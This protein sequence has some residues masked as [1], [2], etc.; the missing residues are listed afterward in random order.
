MIVTDPAMRKKMERALENSSYTLD[1]IEDA[2]LSGK[3]QS[4]VYG[5][6]WIITQV[7][8][9]PRSTAVNILFAVGDLEDTL[10][11]AKMIES[12]AKALGAKTITFTGREGWQELKVPGWKK[13]GVIYSKDIDHG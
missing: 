6:T 10:E 8:E 11:G 4:H 5:N 2:L 9:F 13:V 12:W 1:D 7:Y 3:M